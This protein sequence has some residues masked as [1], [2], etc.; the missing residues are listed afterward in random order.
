ML[1]PLVLMSFS[2]MPC[3]F[4][5]SDTFF[6]L[7]LFSSCAVFESVAWVRMLAEMT[8]ISG[9]AEILPSPLKETVLVVAAVFEMWIV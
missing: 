3:F 7:R 5:K 8:A 9:L 6:D 1:Y 4:K 2:S